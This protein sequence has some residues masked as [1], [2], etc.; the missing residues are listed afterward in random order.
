MTVKAMDNEQGGAIW[1]QY[2]DDFIT[3]KLDLESN[4]SDLTREIIDAYISPLRSM[5]SD[6]LSQLVSL[7]VCFHVHHLDLTKVT[8]ILSQIS[9]VQ[10]EMAILSPKGSLNPTA[11][12][13]PGSLMDTRS[14]SKMPP[15]LGSFIVTMLFDFISNMDTAASEDL[16]CWYRSYH[17]IVSFNLH[18][19]H[20]NNIIT[21][22]NDDHNPLSLFFIDVCAFYGREYF[23][24]P[25][26]ST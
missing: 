21:C 3:F 17:D 20:Y 18:L 7:H 16:Q 5:C 4:P 24:Q 22:V 23:E 13:T 8:R 9:R 26:F 10:N 14:A 15:T 1:R 11:T 25:Y 2:F 6:T 12:L 19:I